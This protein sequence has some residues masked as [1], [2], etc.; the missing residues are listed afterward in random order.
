M[1]WY[2][3]KTGR[4]RQRPHY[5][6]DELE[7]ICEDEVNEFLRGKYGTVAFPGFYQDT[8]SEHHATYTISGNMIVNEEEA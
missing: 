7:Q 4:F 8:R 3:D 2:P 1:R 5:E 6:Q